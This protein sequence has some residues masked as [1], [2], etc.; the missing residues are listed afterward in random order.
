M[1]MNFAHREA[2]KYK[3]CETCRFRTLL[4][5]FDSIGCSEVINTCGV[6]R[7]GTNNYTPEQKHP[8]VSLDQRCDIDAWE[9]FGDQQ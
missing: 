3:L 6:G 9:Y 7:V 2:R 8:E 4:A 1:S 5:I